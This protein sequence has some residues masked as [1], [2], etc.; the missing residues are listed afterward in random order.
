M[1]L[2]GELGAVVDIQCLENHLQVFFHGEDGYFQLVG[3]LLVVPAARH[4]F[5]HIALAGACL[6]ADGEPLSP[7]AR[8]SGSSSHYGL[9]TWF[10]DWGHVFFLEKQALLKKLNFHLDFPPSF[11]VDSPMKAF[12]Q[13]V[14]ELQPSYKMLIS[15]VCL[16]S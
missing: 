11:C 2:G 14:N 8:N 12:D 6:R 4:L 3:N 10:S 1:P 15:G 9:K 5:H 7:V 13:I 16:A